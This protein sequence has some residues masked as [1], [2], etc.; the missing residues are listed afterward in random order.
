MYDEKEP[1]DCHALLE[2]GWT[3]LD[4]RTPDEFAAGHPIGAV[5]VPFSL[6][7]PGGMMQ[8]PAFLSVVRRL[9]SPDS[10]IVIGGANGSRSARACQMLAQMGY[11]SLVH[12]IGGFSGEHDASGQIVALGWAGS[13]L[14]TAAGR[15]DGDYTEVMRRISG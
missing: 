3:Y 8:N 2:S 7:G 13:G 6:I 12:V 10:R 11:G 9:Y 15:G 14:P 5:N 1:R 4:V